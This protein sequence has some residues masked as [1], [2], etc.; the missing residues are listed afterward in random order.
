MPTD[1]ENPIYV[2]ELFTSRNFKRTKAVQ[3]KPDPNVVTLTGKNQNGKSSVI[4]AIWSVIT[5]KLCDRPIRDGAS[6]SE[7]E[8]DF[9]AF[10]ATLNIT[11]KGGASIKV[12]AKD[13][14]P[15]NGPRT[16]LKQHSNEILLDPIGFIRKSESAEGRRE[17]AELLRRLVGLDF[18][19]LDQERQRA[20]NERTIAGRAA[21]ASKSKLTLYPVHDHAPAQEV[22]ATDL[23]NELQAIQKN[24]DEELRLAREHNKANEKIKTTWK[25]AEDLAVEHRGSVE[26]MTNQIRQIEEQLEQLRS[27][28]AKTQA[29][30]EKAETYL[31]QQEAAVAELVYKDEEAI[32]AQTTAAKIPIGVQIESLDTIN[33]KVRANRHHLEIKA[34]MDAAQ[35]KANEYTA[36]I[37]AIDA[38]KEELLSKAKFPIQGLSF[39]DDGILLDGLPFKEDQ[40]SKAQLLR[41]TVAIGLAFNPSIR[42][43]LIQDASLFDRETIKEME[44]IAREHKAQFWLEQIESDNEAA[45]EI[46]DGEVAA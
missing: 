31:K 13:G 43:S 1:T 33:K 44:N 2:I 23:L 30:L 18:T 15:I 7:N 46:V 26:Y 34:E 42:V 24:G 21:D 14:T 16:F 29:D 27:D 6:K 35:A 40:L 38:E 9:G 10:K 20:F 39:N 11:P 5:G 32:L 28:L 17:Q 12:E 37:Q 22:S 4:G 41:A 36:R 25:E 19:K 45:I 8:L 3:F